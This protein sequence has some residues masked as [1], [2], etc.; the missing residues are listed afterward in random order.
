MAQ[1]VLDRPGLAGLSLA[2]RSPTR[3]LWSE[4]YQAH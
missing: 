2:L 1:V 4:P 3:C